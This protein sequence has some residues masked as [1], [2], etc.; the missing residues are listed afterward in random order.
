MDILLK[1]VTVI[2]PASPFHRQQ[3][4]ILLQNGAITEIGQ[5]NHSADQ[6]ISQ[7]GLFISPG[8]TDVFAHF[9][10][11]GFEF[12]ETLE[13][14]AKT[15]ALGGYTDVFLLPNTAPVIHQKG[16]AEYIVQRSKNLPVR[17]HP[18][19]AITKGAEGKELAEMYDMQLSGAI[20]F[21]DGLCGTVGRSA[22][23]GA[24]IR[25]SCTKNS[26]PNARRP[27]HYCT[28]TDE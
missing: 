3:V 19:G 8:F 9:C 1:A 25:K 23:K 16:S 20:V 14:G 24:A 17:L 22:A 13:S 26:H 12:R 18:I 15:A 27:Q 11:P 2:D 4:D 28:W 7:D 10:D 21:S 5:L 6:T